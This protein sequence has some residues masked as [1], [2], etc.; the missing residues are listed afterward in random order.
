MNIFFKHLSIAIVPLLVLGAGTAVV[1]SII[2][3][4]LTSEQISQ[5]TNREVGLHASMFDSFISSN[6]SMVEAIANSPTV[7]EGNPAVIM[8]Y[9]KIEQK[10]LGNILEGLYL[11]DMMGNVLGS[12][13]SAFNVRDRYYFPR[14]IRGEIV[15]TKLL[16]SKDTGRK[17]VL[18]LVP[19]YNYASIFMWLIRSRRVSTRMVAPIAPVCREA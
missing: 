1:S 19:I 12:D 3:E 15:V 10:R 6:V 2:S 18:I 8:G 5:Q 9:L 11:D 4:R 17:I 13:G 16:T 7:R 14:M